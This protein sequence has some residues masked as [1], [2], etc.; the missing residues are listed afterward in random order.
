M[1]TVKVRKHHP[2]GNKPETRQGVGA[3]SPSQF[4]ALIHTDTVICAEM[5]K[6]EAT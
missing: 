6:C 5:T 3:L 2:H 4:P 1:W